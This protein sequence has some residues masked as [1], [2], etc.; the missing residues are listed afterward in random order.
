MLFSEMSL[1]VIVEI[2]KIT[3][4]HTELFYNAQKLQLEK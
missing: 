2:N 3:Q 1:V 4:T